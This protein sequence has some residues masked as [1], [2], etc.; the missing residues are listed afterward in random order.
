MTWRLRNEDGTSLP[1]MQGQQG[2]LTLDDS[3]EDDDGD[4]EEDDGSYLHY[5]AS[6]ELVHCENEQFLDMETVM[7]EL[8]RCGLI[9]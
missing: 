5:L 3:E 6:G 4:G 8:R 2:V 9:P 7:D 1:M